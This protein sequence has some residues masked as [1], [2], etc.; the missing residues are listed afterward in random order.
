MSDINIQLLG[1]QDTDA[2]ASEIHKESFLKDF[3]EINKILHSLNKDVN[4]FLIL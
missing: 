1:L 2:N 4:I 3:Q